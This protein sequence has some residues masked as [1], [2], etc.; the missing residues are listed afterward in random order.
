MTYT[1]DEHAVKDLHGRQMVQNV[2]F[3]A[4]VVY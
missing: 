4:V 3:I 1:C 2:I